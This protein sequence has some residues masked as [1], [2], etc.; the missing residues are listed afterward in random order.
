MTHCSAFSPAP[1]PPSAA[2]ES[3]PMD[4]IPPAGT[5]LPL[6]TISF[7]KRETRSSVDLSRRTLDDAE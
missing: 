3:E 2:V 6:L 7:T 4:G 1:S 5:T